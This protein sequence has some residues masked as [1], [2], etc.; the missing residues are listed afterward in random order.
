MWFTDLLCENDLV[1]TT[2]AASGPEIGST[3]SASL[4]GQWESAF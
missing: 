2:N 1:L 4:S 3:E